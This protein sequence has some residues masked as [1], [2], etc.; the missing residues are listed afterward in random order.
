MTATA[1]PRSYE[2]MAAYLSNPLQTALLAALLAAG[3]LH[4]ASL[5]AAALLFCGAEIA[6]GIRRSPGPRWIPGPWP[7]SPAPLTVLYDASC[8][9]CAGSKARLER[10][11]T[12]PSMR[13]VPLRSPEARALVPGLREEEYFGAM[14]VVEDGRVYSAH[15]AWFRLMRLAPVWLAWLSWVTPRFV[16]RPVY[17]RVARDRYRWFGR[18]CEE[19][20]CAVHPG[21]G[22][23]KDPGRPTA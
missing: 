13:F 8:R 17:A 10:W 21:K 9:L 15:E 22:A 4:P 20:I 11:R 7:R 16:A 2:G 23:G 5:A 3:F 14:H 12:A 19:G 1:G 18:V 6:A